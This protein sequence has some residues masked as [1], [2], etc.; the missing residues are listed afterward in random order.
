MKHRILFTFAIFVFGVL[1]ASCNQ[2]PIFYIISK[3][4]P[5]QKAYI[6]GTPTKMVVFK[7]YSEEIPILYVASG[8]Q[9]H[10]YAKP[11]ENGNPAGK[12]WDSSEYSTPQPIGSGRIIDIAASSDHLYALCMNESN[13]NATLWRIGAIDTAWQQVANTSGYTLIQTVYADPDEKTVFAGVRTSSTTDTTDTYAILYMKDSD[14]ELKVLK[15][16]T[17]MLQ[18]AVFSTDNFFLLATRGGGIYRVSKTD[19]DT[20][21]I[22]DAVTQLNVTQQADNEGVPENIEKNR[23]FM[24]IIKIELENNVINIIAV[25]REGGSL[26]EYAGNAGFSRMKYA[27]KS[28]VTV[29]PYSTGALALWESKDTATKILTAGLRTNLISATSYTNGYVEF[30]LDN[31]D[32]SIKN[33]NSPP[34]ITVVDPDQYSSSIGQKTITYMFQAHIDEDMTFFASTQN[35]GLWSYRFIGGV[36][37]WNAETNR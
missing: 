26:Y 4:Q 33:R 1:A 37:Q 32:G 28:W 15:E 23:M 29:G 20:D 11:G 3:E 12:W 17:T 34:K 7:R 13:L 5:L 14:S 25:E 19:I 9:L 24:G 18:G 16:N 27:D 8:T 2:D 10:W 6:P 22:T 30:E 36:K 35:A 21:N 31:T